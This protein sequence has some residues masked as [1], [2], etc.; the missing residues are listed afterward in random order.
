MKKIKYIIITAV[1]MAFGLGAAVYD[2]NEDRPQFDDSTVLVI[3]KSQNTGIRLYSVQSASNSAYSVFDELGVT[4][5]EK[6]A[7]IPSENTSKGAISLFSVSSASADKDILKLTLP[8]SGE[9]NVLA[10]VTKLNE[11]GTVEYAQPDYYYY[12]DSYTPN[13]TYYSGRQYSLR[14]VNAPGV[15]D[16]DIHCTAVTVAVLDSGMLTTHEDLAG[17]LWTNPDTDS[18]VVHGWDFTTDTADVTDGIGHGTHVS[19]IVSADTN[20]NKGIASLARDA[21][22]APFAVFSST[23][24][25]KTS[26]IIKA[27][28]YIREMDF[29]IANCSWGSDGFPLD[30][31]LTVSQKRDPDKA[32]KDSMSSCKNTL[33]VTA[34]GN[35]GQDIDETPY[36]PASFSL[37]NSIAVAATDST[38]SL[39]VFSGTKSSS[40]GV[41]TVD[42]AAPGSN[43]YSTIKSSVSSYGYDGGTSMSTPLVASAAAVIKARYPD[44]TP[45][46]IKECILGGADTV[47]TLDDKINGARRLNAYGALAYAS[48]LYCMVTWMDDNGNVIDRTEVPKGTIP[49]H[50]VPTKDSTEEF[51]YTFSGWTPEIEAVTE[52]ITYTAQFRA[53]SNTAPKAYAEVTDKYSDIFSIE[54]T[55]AEN[56]N[57]LLTVIP[58]QDTEEEIPN[59]FAYV[60][61]YSTDGELQEIVKKEFDLSA[62]EIESV[63]DKQYKLFI[64]TDLFEPVINSISDIDA[65]LIQS[66]Q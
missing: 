1:I 61:V 36:Y 57:I 50:V 20:N 55:R 15:W 39:A 11:S 27:I 63:S 64:W 17:N 8:E 58:K 24:S 53:V 12:L 47:S 51:S 28:E 21:K 34:A 46:K 5:I 16:I 30:D 54:L 59:L 3:M 26:W 18:E 48:E 19:G 29:P 49:S 62:V 45:A 43:I 41:N 52:D 56:N 32:L 23:G 22:I 13:D 66:S 2:D 42:I 35:S 33:F 25:S 4:D 65:M 44:M 40:Y 6:I 9:E 38:D 10:A 7:S 60:A 14:K 37:D 31:G